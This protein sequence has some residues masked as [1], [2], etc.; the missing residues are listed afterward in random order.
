MGDKNDQ[1]RDTSLAGL[2]LDDEDVAFLSS[3]KHDED[4]SVSSGPASQTRARD[5]SPEAAD[6]SEFIIRPLYWNDP[7]SGMS[8]RALNALK[9]TGVATYGELLASDLDHLPGIGSGTRESL[10]QFFYACASESPSIYLPDRAERQKLLRLTRNRQL[11]WGPFGQLHPVAHQ[12]ETAA[13]DTTELFGKPASASQDTDIP[14]IPDELDNPAEENGETSEGASVPIESL[15]LSEPLTRRLKG[16]GYRTVADVLGASD[17]ALLDIRSLGATSLKRIREATG[18]YIADPNSRLVKVSVDLSP[19]QGDQTTLDSTT[20]SKAIA[21]LLMRH[22]YRTIGELAAASRTEL[23]RIPGL[24]AAKLVK[25][26][27]ALEEALDGLPL[28]Y[29]DEAISLADDAKRQLAI[30][31]CSIPEAPYRFWTLPIAQALID[32]GAPNTSLLIEQLE[33]IDEPRLGADNSAEKM[34]LG[35]WIDQLQSKGGHAALL[36][37]RLAGLT[38]EQIGSD[39]GV[40][41]ERIRQITKKELDVRPPLIEDKYL[42]LVRHYEISKDT[43][44]RTFEEPPFVFEYLKLVRGRAGRLPL[45]QSL[46]DSSIDLE[47]RKA[48]N[49][50]L[51]SQRVVVGVFEVE[52]R[53]APLAQAVFETLASERPIDPRDF[54]DAYQAVLPEHAINNRSLAFSDSAAA[55]RFIRRQDYCTV[56]TDG[57]RYYE[58]DYPRARHLVDGIDFSKYEGLEISAALIYRDY[59][60]L[61]KEL[62][63]R[64]GYELHTALR[65]IMDTW[66]PEELS[67]C[68]LDRIP[69]LSFGSGDLRRLQLE[70]LAR[71]LAPISVDE[72]CEAYECRYGIAAPSIGAVVRND[73]KA[74][75]EGNSIVM[76][77]ETKLPETTIALVRQSISQGLRTIGGIDRY[78]ARELEKT[79]G[80]TAQSINSLPLLRAGFKLSGQCVFLPEETPAAV[81][82]KMMTQDRLCLTTIEHDIKTCTEFRSALAKAHRAHVLIQVDRDLYQSGR[83]LGLTPQECE[84]FINA[85]RHDPRTAKPFNTKSLRQDGFTHPLLSKGLTDIMGDGLL[86]TDNHF[87]KTSANYTQIFRIS[88]EPIRMPEV[89]EHL[90]ITY[91]ARTINDVMNLLNI[92]FGAQ[93]R[94]ENVIAWASKCQTYNPETKR[95]SASG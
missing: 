50:Y 42:P 87:R 84:D 60:S 66:E 72:F 32:C 11:V 37:D 57:I 92:R 78:V 30:A 1:A 15:G 45:E 28:P 33:M 83:S 40:T 3:I 16:N 14:F 86:D 79:A 73:F 35:D 85:V 18:Q 39:E 77:P 36:V 13:I 8:S 89:I 41:R 64:D 95:F 81:F 46:G 19:L 17:K 5:D 21:T 4:D 34:T 68:H 47:Q 88:Q 58:L 22:G 48:I 31:D 71:E 55:E 59:P 94:R 9:R 25:I 2:I 10:E 6:I 65:K 52:Q 82:G 20:L 29:S 61:M 27:K 69:T 26:E 93:P 75:V 44:C 74:L 56:A 91:Q 23:T 54:F 53:K 7:L 70:N 80:E 12:P 90:V 62:D 76:P 51:K 43:F 63:I 38:L 49:R 67:T 24:G